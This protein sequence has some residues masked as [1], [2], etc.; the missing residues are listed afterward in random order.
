MAAARG[1]D[2]AAACRTAG[3]GRVQREELG[4][5][6]DLAE[7]GLDAGHRPDAGP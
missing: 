6:A 1:T 2:S 7:G 4:V 5:G 3:R